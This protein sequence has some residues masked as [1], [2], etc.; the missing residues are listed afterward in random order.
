[1]IIVIFILFFNLKTDYFLLCGYLRVY[2]CYL[3]VDVKILKS[4]ICNFLPD[5]MTFERFT[6]LYLDTVI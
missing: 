4:M 1:M 5:L 3:P 2:E 6:S